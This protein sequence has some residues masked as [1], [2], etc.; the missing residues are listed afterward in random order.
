MAP[1]YS[2]GV[3]RVSVFGKDGA[4]E[5][6]RAEFSRRLR[7]GNLGI[8][9]FGPF[10]RQFRGVDGDANFPV[11]VVYDTGAS[12]PSRT[13]G[14]DVGGFCEYA[15]GGWGAGCGIGCDLCGIARREHVL[16][17]HERQQLWPFNMAGHWRS[18]ERAG[19]LRS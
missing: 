7:D 8:S 11:T 3:C 16:R 1:E 19:R 4:G 13:G 14:Y 10:I 18:L 12:V 17:W 15:W 5:Q 2:D 9:L 6:I